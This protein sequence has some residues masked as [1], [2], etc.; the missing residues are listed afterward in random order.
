MHK[1]N[2]RVC[3]NIFEWVENIIDDF[4]KEKY[5]EEKTSFND[6]QRIFHND[7]LEIFLYIVPILV[8]NFFID[9]GVS[10]IVKP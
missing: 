9:K 8:H 10:H 6:M 5:I 2:N 4:I 1:L 7:I 3:T